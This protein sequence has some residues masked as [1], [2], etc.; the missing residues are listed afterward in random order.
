MNAVRGAQLYS[1][2]MLLSPFSNRCRFSL[3]HIE[4]DDN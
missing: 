3:Q 2:Y 1:R 4:Q